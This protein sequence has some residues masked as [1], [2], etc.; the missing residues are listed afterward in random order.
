MPFRGVMDTV[1]TNWQF[2]GGYH[3]RVELSHRRN[4]FTAN[5]LVTLKISVHIA[6]LRWADI[7]CFRLPPIVIFRQITRNHSFIPP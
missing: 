7:Q 4:Q 3:W 6:E 5:R 1:S 2:I